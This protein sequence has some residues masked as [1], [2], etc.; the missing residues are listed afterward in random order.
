MINDIKTNNQK[1]AQ[2]LFKVKYDNTNPLT[3]IYT[4]YA[5]STTLATGTLWC[6]DSTGKTGAYTAQDDGHDITSG[7]CQ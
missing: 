5:I 7:T 4:G 6:I 1:N 3:H 2:V